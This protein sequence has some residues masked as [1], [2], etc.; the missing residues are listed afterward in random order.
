MRVKIGIVFAVA[1]ALFFVSA[2]FSNLLI[3]TIEAQRAFQNQMAAAVLA[4]RNGDPGAYFALLSAAGA[5]GF[6]HALGV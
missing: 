6:V 4:I 2:D 3:W 1:A 5:Y